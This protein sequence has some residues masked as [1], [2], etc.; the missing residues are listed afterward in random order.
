MVNMS[1]PEEG[2]VAPETK[3]ELTELR[4]EEEARGTATAA[5]V[6]IVMGLVTLDLLRRCIVI[7][8]AIVGEYVACVGMCVLWSGDETTGSVLK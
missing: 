3:G 5:E 7:V 2:T 4:L 8:L 1:T 6:E